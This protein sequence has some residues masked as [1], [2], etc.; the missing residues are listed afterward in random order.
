MIKNKNY[1][2]SKYFGKIN[3]HVKYVQLLSLEC[4]QIYFKQKI[5]VLKIVLSLI[6]NKPPRSCLSWLSIVRKWIFFI[7][8]TPL[9]N[10][11]STNLIFWLKK[12]TNI[13]S[14]VHVE[15]FYSTFYILSRWQKWPDISILILNNVFLI[16]FFNW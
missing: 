13:A 5:L 7:V 6:F 10:L 3:S 9:F 12:L 8:A 16:L 4:A 14:P 2:G 11:L 1:P 15:A